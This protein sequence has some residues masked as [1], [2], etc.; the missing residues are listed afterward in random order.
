MRFLLIICCSVTVFLSGC[1]A[2]RPQ[3][4]VVSNVPKSKPVS[5]EAVRR[6]KTPLT[7]AE[8]ERVFGPATGDKKLI[9]TY[10]CT[11]AMSIV[12]WLEPVKKGEPNPN[13]NRLVNMIMLNYSPTIVAI[14]LPDDARHFDLNTLSKQ[15]FG[16]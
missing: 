3:P 7:I 2:N 14:I 10:P 11:D 4:A 16:N 8:V 13:P 15:Q 12:F 6:L 1:A 5:I 9:V